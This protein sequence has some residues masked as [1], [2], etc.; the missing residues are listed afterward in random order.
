MHILVTGGAGFIGSH[1]VEH[2]LAKGDAVHVVDNLSTGRFE[3]I[4]PFLDNPR[5]HFD[6]ADILTWAGLEKAAT[7]ADR[8]YHMAAVVGV[9]RVLEDP[10]RVLATNIAGTERLLRFASAGRWKPQIVIASSSEVYGPTPAELLREDA[11]LYVQS[12]G[13]SRWNYALSKL[14]DEA[15]GLSYARQYN[16]PICVVRLFNTVGPRQTG[17]YGMVLPRFVEQALS[18]GPI[19]IYGGGTQTRSFCDVRDTVVA[20]DLLADTPAAS[21]EIV[22]VGND[23]EISISA[24]A[25]LVCARAKMNVER[26]HLSYVEAYGQQYDDIL[27]RKPSLEKLV[28]LTGFTHQWRLEETLDDLIAQYRKRKAG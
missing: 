24:L 19:T 11:M 14:A 18:G 26:Q 6:E 13:K 3:N 9:F 22:N 25:D 2:H 23:R 5:F 17:R 21:G 28:R 1:L 15:Q 8:I 16:I 7:W 4:E 27:R 20:L 12:A 10:I